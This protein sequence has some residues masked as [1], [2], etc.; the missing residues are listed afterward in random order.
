[1]I[2]C[3]AGKLD[4]PAPASELY[5]GSMFRHTYENVARLAAEDRAAGRGGGQVRI[6]VLS[7]LHGLVEVDQQIEPYDLKMGAAGSVTAEQVRAQAQALGMEWGDS[8]HYDED[9]PGE[10]YALLP[11]AYLAVLDEA[12]RG[13]D[14]YVQDV[15]EGCGSI[16][17]QRRVNAIIG[18]PA[19]EPVEQLGDSLHMWIGGDVPAIWWGLPVLLSYGRLRRAKSLPVAQAPWVCDSRGFNEIREHGKWTIPVEEYAADLNRYADQIGRLKWAAPQD[20][21]AAQIMLDRTGL[22]EAEH[23]T[24][25]IDGYERLVPLTHVEVIYVLTGKD[26]AGY[27]RHLDMWKARGY[28]LTAGDKVVGVGALVGRPAAEAAQIIRA[29][30]AAGVRRMHGFGVKGPVLAL[31]GPLLESVDSSDWSGENRREAQAAGELGLCPHGLVRYERN[32]RVYAQA[33][34]RRQLAVA[35]QAMVQEM[36]PLG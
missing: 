33:W 8:G 11:K 31:V 7:A 30:H 14:V 22:T 27:L 29:L 24:L 23:Q 28:D 1:V 25:T 18:R 35:D 2:P 3:G 19:V 9:L 16:F 13:V 4:R 10:V 12:L 32:C 15:Y 17:D 20:W 6:L 34:A 5:T 21:P 26:L 36:L